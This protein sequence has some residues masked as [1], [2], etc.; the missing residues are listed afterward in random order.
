[1]PM[2]PYPICCYRP[3][4]QRPAVY[5]IAARWSDG[6]THE[7]KT[8]ALSCE[9]CL[10]DWFHR[11]RAKQAA[12]RLAAG[13]TLEPPGIYGLERGW[14]DQQLTRRPDLEAGLA[15]AVT[16]SSAASGAIP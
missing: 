8:Y 15:D 5:K 12:C 3:G 11:S 1:M 16:G 13:E 9:D 2:P 4:C 14:R 10:A 7:L 6:V